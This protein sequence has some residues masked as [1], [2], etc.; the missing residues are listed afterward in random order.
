[1]IKGDNMVNIGDY[2]LE[3][4]LKNLMPLGGDDEKLLSDFLSSRTNKTAVFFSPDVLPSESGS[5]DDVK[6]RLIKSKYREIDTGFLCLPL[7]IQKYGIEWH[8]P[9]FGIYKY[10]TSNH[11]RIRINR[12]DDV[13]NIQ[14]KNEMK[15][16]DDFSSDK[17]LY[18][19]LFINISKP[20]IDNVTQ[21][22]AITKMHND[23]LSFDLNEGGLFK[24]KYKRIPNRTDFYFDSLMKTFLTQ[25]LKKSVA[26]SKIY[27]DDPQLFFFVEND[28]RDFNSKE[29]FKLNVIVVG[30]I[31]EKYF[32][33]DSVDKSEVSGLITATYQ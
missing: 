16:K 4:H 27:F 10:H 5:L 19:D 22:Y 25:K 1:M 11:F 28:G 32:L 29:V 8:M 9:R 15:S 26:D 33:I 24:V 20:M 17:T 21:N 6:L 30:R 18:K 31:Y 3:K 12:N 2:D 7:P 14:M 13:L 23:G